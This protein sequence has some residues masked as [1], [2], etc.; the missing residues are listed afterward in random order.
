M[1]VVYRERDTAS[2]TSRDNRV[3][4]TIGQNSLPEVSQ[5]HGHLKLLDPVVWIRNDSFL[6][7]IFRV[8]YL[9]HVI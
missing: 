1:V 6:L 9:T 7:Q 4:I 3:I 8:P 5:Q 2:I